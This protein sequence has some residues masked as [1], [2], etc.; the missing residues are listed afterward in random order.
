MTQSIHQTIYENLDY[1][2]HLAHAIRIIANQH[3]DDNNVA[4]AD[5]LATIAD[6]MHI[7]ITNINNAVHVL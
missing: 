1:A 4:M 3:Y 6:D 2:H 7:T 5:R